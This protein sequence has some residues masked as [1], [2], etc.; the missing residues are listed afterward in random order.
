MPRRPAKVGPAV[1]ILKAEDKGFKRGF[2]AGEQA[3][4]EMRAALEKLRTSVQKSDEAANGYL[5]RL[6]DISVVAVATRQIVGPL[7]TD[8]VNITKQSASLSTELARISRAADISVQRLFGLSIVFAKAGANLEKTADLLQ[9]VGERIADAGDNATTYV[10]LFRRLGISIR[11]ENGTLRSA[12][13]VLLELPDALNRLGSAEANLASTD[14]FGDEGARAMHEVARAGNEAFRATVEAAERGAAGLG[15][16]VQDGRKTHNT[17][18]E[19]SQAS[20]QFKLALSQAFGPL[21]RSGIELT[22]ALLRD[23]HNI[24]IRFRS[25]VQHIEAATADLI[26]RTESELSRVSDQEERQSI[27]LAALAENA[28]TADVRLARVRHELRGLREDL[29]RLEAEPLAGVGVDPGELRHLIRLREEEERAAARGGERLREIY[30]SI[31]SG[32]P[33]LPPEFQKLE[34]ALN[35]VLTPSSQ[36]LEILRALPDDTRTAFEGLTNLPTAEIGLTERAVASLGRAISSAALKPLDILPNRELFVRAIRVYTEAKTKLDAVKQSA[37][38]AEAEAEAARALENLISNLDEAHNRYRSIADT[39]AIAVDSNR[40]LADDFQ[41]AV[42]FA[43]DTFQ[44]AVSEAEALRGV[45]QK[46]PEDQAAILRGSEVWAT[47]IQ[48]FGRAQEAIEAY[49]RSEVEASDP[50]QLIANR[51]LLLNELR[52]YQRDVRELQTRL[53]DSLPDLAP[54]TRLVVDAEFRVD[55]DS[56]EVSLAEARGLL[57][58]ASSA[59]AETG[60]TL[61]E[62][63]GRAALRSS[64]AYR[65][66]SQTLSETAGAGRFLANDLQRMA[67]SADFTS[68]AVARVRELFEQLPESQS[69]LLRGSRVWDALTARFHGAQAAVTDFARAEREA[70]DPSQLIANRQRL[71]TELRDYQGDVR[72]LQDRLI[73]VLPSLTPETQVLIDAEFRIDAVALENSL[74][75]AQRVLQSAGVEQEQINDTLGEGLRRAAMRANADYRS[76]RGSIESVSEAGRDLVEDLRKVPSAIDP[77]V[78]SAGRLGALM[79]R[80]PAQQAE[81]LRGSDVWRVLVQRFAAAQGAVE[82]Y[83]R[84]EAQ[85]SDPSEF[86]YNRRRLTKDIEAYQRDIEDLQGRLAASLP[87]LTLDTRVAV[88]AEFDLD[89]DLLQLSLDDAQRALDSSRLSVDISDV[90]LG[91]SLRHAILAATADSRDLAVELESGE[92]AARAAAEELGLVKT[93]AEEAAEQARLLQRFLSSRTADQRSA[94]L[95]SGVWHDLIQQLRLAQDTVARYA[96]EER[97]ALDA[98]KS[99]EGRRKLVANLEEMERQIEQLSEKLAR[100][101]VLPTDAESAVLDVLLKPDD[102]ELEAALERTR[103]RLRSTEELSRNIGRALSDGIQHAVV[104]ADTL[105][106]ALSDIGRSIAGLLLQFGLGSLPGGLG[107]FFSGTGFGGARAG[108]GP[109]SPGRAYLVGETGPEL[110]VPRSAGRIEAS[111]SGVT[112][113]FAPTIQST[114]QGVVELID[115]RMATVWGPQLESIAR[116]TVARDNRRPNRMQVRGR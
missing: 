98:E 65:D 108:G 73:A 82:N 86:A 92:D 25:N 15:G 106:E 76:M 63:L 113:N 74:A 60:G 87:D 102:S 88:A 23:A 19:L 43:V 39:L 91:E 4:K 13:E 50:S 115:T 68:S 44:R 97:E 55:I 90:S 42:T 24:L 112:I 11:R 38:D 61:G 103:K 46:I 10:E 107:S 59:F 28:A 54:A 84:A 37:L 21:V 116:S 27:I 75:E 51:K 45:F 58:T 94:L 29:L 69:A 78:Q 18:I 79:G 2:A 114:D 9:T 53:I 72:N 52:D 99:L 101:G 33:R 30:Q 104:Q 85:A 62:A 32:E 100:E 64:S 40:Q 35:E 12:A 16:L 81:V 34:A 93:R 89:T 48:R 109:V 7:L 80:L 20:N 56:L 36:F 111:P 83:A 5:A 96:R 105:G 31:F 22:I 17:L 66:M 14:L 41:P 8:I 26:Q 3:I 1:A 49:A 77:A 6:R 57:Q 110:F 47:L 71:L 95:D 70:S 67:E